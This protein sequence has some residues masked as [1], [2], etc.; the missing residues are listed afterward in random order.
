VTG[1]ARPAWHVAR[2]QIRVQT[3]TFQQMYYRIYTH[4]QSDDRD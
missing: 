1:D 2:R 4:A 3:L